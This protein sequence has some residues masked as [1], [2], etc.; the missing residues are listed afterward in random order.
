M[1]LT[2]LPIKLEKM[3]D[4]IGYK[5][6]KTFRENYLEPL[7]QAELIVKTNPDNPNDPEQKYVITEKGKLFLSGKEFD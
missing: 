1:V 5:N 3:M 4:W 6:R 2:S 7:Q